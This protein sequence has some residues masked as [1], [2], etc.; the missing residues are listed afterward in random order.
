M[1]FIILAA[2]CCLLAAS[3]VNAEP[4]RQDQPLQLSNFTVKDLDGNDVSFNKYK[5]KCVLVIN[6][7]SGCGFT[8]P[9]MKYLNELRSDATYGDLAIVAFPSNTFGQEPKTPAELKTWFFD[10]WKAKYDVYGKIDVKQSDVYKFLIDA[11]GDETVI[12]NY[13]KYI[14]EKDGT[15]ATRYGPQAGAI[16]DWGFTKHL[17]NCVNP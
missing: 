2:F 6:T 3:A 13:G 16:F 15:K 9:N 10:D 4:E 12:W 14:V 1:K 11:A 8:K 17:K 7:A 5:G